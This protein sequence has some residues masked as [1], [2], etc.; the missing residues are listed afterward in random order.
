MSSIRD[1]YMNASSITSRSTADLNHGIALLLAFLIAAASVIYTCYWS[2]HTEGLRV[3]N[4]IVTD[5]DYTLDGL[6]IVI[7]FCLG[8]CVVGLWSRKRWGLIIAFLALASVIATY[9]R[10]YRTTVKYLSELQNYPE[11]YRRVRQEVGFFH[12]ATKWDHVV[13]A[14]VTIL[15][16][17]VL[18][19]LV[20]HRRRELGN[21]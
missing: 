3:S 16:L 21:V 4:G 7:S 13:L 10:W 20:I 2:G 6:H 1:V 8:L 9:A 15:L 18:V 17:W 19:R 14:L 11:L 5:F 12:G